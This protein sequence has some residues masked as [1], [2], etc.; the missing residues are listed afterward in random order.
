MNLVT[1]PSYLSV[2]TSSGGMLRWAKILGTCF[3][4]CI[5]LR[6]LLSNLD[7]VN[8]SSRGYSNW[9][10]CNLRLFASLLLLTHSFYLHIRANYR[11]WQAWDGRL[12]LLL[13]CV[14]PEKKVGFQPPINPTAN[15]ICGRHHMIWFSCCFCLAKQ[16]KYEVNYGF[17]RSLNIW[18]SD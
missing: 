4:Q 16:S 15:M 13:A 3:H 17:W 1:S 5:P 14:L 12:L 2:C 10:P 6:L 8:V 9:V 11:S 18:L 7:S